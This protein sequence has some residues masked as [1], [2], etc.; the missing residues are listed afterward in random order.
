MATLPFTASPP[1]PAYFSSVQRA[2]AATLRYLRASQLVR[3]RAVPVEVAPAAAAHDG[4]E[5]AELPVFTPLEAMVVQIGKSDP[6]PVFRPDNRLARFGGLLFGLKPPR[7]LADPRL[8]GLRLLVIALRQRGGRPQEA[9]DA[10]SQAG[11]SESQLK[12]LVAELRPAW[13]R[14]AAS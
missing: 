9:V 14:Q 13:N 8:E 2:D 1:A 3:F 12:L 5:A 4:S 6:L 11:V 10:A 7:P